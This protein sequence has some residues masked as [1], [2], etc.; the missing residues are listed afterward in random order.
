MSLFSVKT[1]A[2]LDMLLKQGVDINTQDYL[3]QTFLHVLVQNNHWM[4]QVTMI[5]Y[6]LQK[7][8]DPNIRNYLGKT[9]IF[10]AQSPQVVYTLRYYGA[11]LYIVDNDGNTAMKTNTNI[12]PLNS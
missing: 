6:V 8:A 3:Q 1:P 7:G 12:R 11:K 5:N 9:P 4:S 2:Q 10:Y